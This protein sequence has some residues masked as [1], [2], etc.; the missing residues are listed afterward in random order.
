MDA[1]RPLG[2][3]ISKEQFRKEAHISK[4]KALELIQQGLIPAID[5]HRQTRRYWIARADLAAYLQERRM[6]PEK[7][8]R[9]RPLKVLCQGKFVQYSSAAAAKLRKAIRLAWADQPDMLSAA[10]ISNLLGYD[11]HTITQWLK[12]WRVGGVYTQRGRLYS[13]K[14]LITAISGREAQAMKYKSQQHFDLLRR[15]IHE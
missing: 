12:R 2:D 8:S 10:A 13:K 7:Y 9:K 3:Y 5:T 11:D 15:A 6:T 1:L 4:R 14:S